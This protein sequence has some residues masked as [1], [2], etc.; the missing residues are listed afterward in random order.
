M[1]TVTHPWQSVLEC[2]KK[3]LPI[4]KPSTHGFKTEIPDLSNTEAHSSIQSLYS[5]VCLESSAVLHIPHGRSRIHEYNDSYDTSMVVSPGMHDK[6]IPNL[7]VP[8]LLWDGTPRPVAA[9]KPTVAL[10]WSQLDRLLLLPPLLPPH[11]S[12]Q[13]CLG[14]DTKCDRC[15]Q[16]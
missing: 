3:W 12:L 4:C 15:Q 6:V 1:N 13:S 16:F 9:L 14:P 8:V 5:T 11:C 2:K 10:E 7:Q